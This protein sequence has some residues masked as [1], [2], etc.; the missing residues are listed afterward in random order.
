MLDIAAAGKCCEEYALIKNCKILIQRSCD[1]QGNSYIEPT[2]T[3]LYFQSINFL[4]HAS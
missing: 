1:D 4:V 2:I 3:T